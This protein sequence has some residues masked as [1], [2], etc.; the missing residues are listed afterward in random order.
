MDIC[1]DMS[2]N[3]LPSLKCE[4]TVNELMRFLKVSRV[5][6]TTTSYWNHI[7]IRNEVILIFSVIFW[8]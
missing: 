2:Y 7:D 1:Y 6:E 4:L 3:M 8:M 5:R